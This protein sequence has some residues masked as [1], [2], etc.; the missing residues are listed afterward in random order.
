MAQD[1]RVTTDAL[2]EG[3]TAS[4]AGRS[5]P[6]IRRRG[7]SE[8][9]F[10]KRELDSPW[11][12][13][14]TVSIVYLALIAKELDVGLPAIVA[15]VGVAGFVVWF[16][17][18]SWLAKRFSDAATTS[19]EEL[20]DPI[21]SLS[22][23]V[24]A[25]LRPRVIEAET[26]VRRSRGRKILWGAVTWVV[27]FAS[28][29][30]GFSSFSQTGKLSGVSAAILG[31][32]VG[33]APYLLVWL[34]WWVTLPMDADAKAATELLTALKLVEDGGHRWTEPRFKRVLIRHL[35]RVAVSLLRHFNRQLR[36]GRRDRDTGA[37][38]REQ[39]RQLAAAIR[40]LKLWV[41]LP[42]ASSK[43]DLRERLAHDFVC[44]VTGEWHELPRGDV[45][46]LSKRGGQLLAAAKVTV[47]VAALAVIFVLPMTE[48]IENE[49]FE[50]G[51][52]GALL[53]VGGTALVS[54]FQSKSPSKS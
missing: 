5:R 1:D 29:L 39:G 15:G 22:P 41:S 35:E 7:Q 18:S 50:R 37:R 36:L 24:K 13:W 14:L 49:D 48:W 42:G 33:L 46:H 40:D 45:P 10:L 47:A 54:L 51:V 31:L 26:R 11:P 53:P 52:Q 32:M 34:T 21:E 8:R 23:D 28:V 27:V 12:Y 16:W 2:S 19:V 25:R 30:V 38:L 20:F 17:H 9:P 4:D 43:D 44:T 3:A 6:S